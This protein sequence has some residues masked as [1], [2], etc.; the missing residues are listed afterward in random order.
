MMNP[1][2]L[3]PETRRRAALSEIHKRLAAMRVP[4][5]A[6]APPI[7]GFSEDPNRLPSLAASRPSPSPSRR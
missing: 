5:Y 3:P 6:F 1:L 4:D 7:R 2:L